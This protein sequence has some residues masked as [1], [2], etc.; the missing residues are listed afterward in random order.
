MRNTRRSI[1]FLFVA[2]GLTAGTASLAQDYYVSISGD[3]AFPGTLAQPWRH[4]QYALDQAG[5]FWTVHVMGGVYNEELTFVSGGS[6]AGPLTL[7]NYLS[8]VAV[9]DGTGLNADAVVTIQDLSHIDVIG[10]EIR[11]NVHNDAIGILVNGLCQGIDLLGLNVHD[12]HFSSDPNA[13]VND[14]TNAQPI[15]V[16]G[17]NAS[18]ALNELTIADCEVHDCRPGFSEGLAI[19]GNVTD[20]VVRNNH[21]HHI[22]NIGIGLIGHEG[23]CPDP[24]LDQARSG[25][26]LANHVHDC[27]SPYAMC[28]GIYVDGARDLIIERNM[29]HDGMW[30]IE[31]GCEHVGKSA[32]N[33]AVRDNVVYNNQGSALM[34]GGYDYPNGSGKVESCLIRHNTFYHNDTQNAFEGELT[35]AYS[36]NCTIAHNIL[37]AD[38]SNNALFYLDDALPLSP[39]LTLDHN[40]WY[41]PGGAANAE[42]TYHSDSYT[43]YA[44]YQSGSGQDTNSPFGDAQFAD[45]SLPDPDLHIASTSPARDAGDIAFVASLTETD[46]DNEVRVNGTVDIGADEYY[47]NTDVAEASVSQGWSAYPNPSSG[48][49]ALHGPV[50]PAGSHLKVIDARGRAILTQQLQATDRVQL[51]LSAFAPGIYLIRIEAGDLPFVAIRSVVQ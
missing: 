51:D 39:G 15:I 33:I 19:N 31:V 17:S 45:A 12:I 40:L 25:I 42:I 14:N 28:G 3:D 6:S 47:S 20:F 37:F 38:N 32:L 29:V 16:Y 5:P 26:I 46:M 24:I 41:C 34:L 49:F 43:G 22:T 11:N 4:V 2:F 21:V 10:L 35:L 18:S 27:I 50:L 7:R 23:T 36:E 8:E 1:R 9:I 13:P 44:D 48:I 30:G